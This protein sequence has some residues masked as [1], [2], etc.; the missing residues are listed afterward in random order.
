MPRLEP[1]TGLRPFFLSA[2][3]TTWRATGQGSHWLP[4]VELGDDRVL[5]VH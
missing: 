4:T 2:A 3:V 1:L 5:V